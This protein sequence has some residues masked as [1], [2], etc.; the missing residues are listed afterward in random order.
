MNAETPPTFAEHV[1]SISASISASYPA[2]LDPEAHTWRRVMK[3]AEE[4]G[5]VTQSLSGY[6]GENPRKGQTHTL[7][8]LR[9]ELL[10]VALAALGAVSHLGGDDDDTAAMLTQRAAF[11]HQRLATTL[12]KAQVKDGSP[13]PSA[14]TLSLVAYDS[15]SPVP[16]W[17]CAGCGAAAPGWA[18]WPGEEGFEGWIQCVCGHEEWVDQ[19]RQRCADTPELG[20]VE[21]HGGIVYEALTAIVQAIQDGRASAQR[22]GMDD[23]T[24]EWIGLTILERF[25]VAPY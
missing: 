25:D 7:D 2:D 17:V 4:V 21:Y 8:D 18:L 13:E 3:V 6:L 19:A 9:S 20:A 16:G 23:T 15:S 24:D 1:R 22:Q 12:G 14:G 5:K 11:I 10:D